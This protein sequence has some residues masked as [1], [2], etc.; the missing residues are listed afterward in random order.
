MRRIGRVLLALSLL[1]PT[2]A[3]MKSCGGG[4]GHME[5]GVTTVIAQAWYSMQTGHSGRQPFPRVDSALIAGSA[6][7]HSLHA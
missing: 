4:M 7:R 2:P 1:V 6:P 5:A 3:L